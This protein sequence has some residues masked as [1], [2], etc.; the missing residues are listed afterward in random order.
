MH[1]LRL[2][3]SHYLWIKKSYSPIHPWETQSLVGLFVAVGGGQA[4]GTIKQQ[5]DLRNFKFRVP[6]FS[7]GGG[8]EWKLFSLST[9]WDI[10]RPVSNNP[11]RVKFSF[12]TVISL[13]LKLNFDLFGT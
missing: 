6:F 12:D 13:G 5:E 7:V 9:I 3:L 11:S 10:Y 4:T 1:K 2:L 8:Y